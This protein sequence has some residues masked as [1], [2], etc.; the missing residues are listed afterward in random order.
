MITLGMP[1]RAASS[2]T[3]A[4]RSGL[5]ATSTVSGRSGRASSEGKQGW[6]NSSSYRGFTK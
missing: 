2:V 1:S 6:S 3:D 4:A 5:S